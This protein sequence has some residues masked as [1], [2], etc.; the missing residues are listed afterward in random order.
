MADYDASGFAGGI[1]WYR[2]MDLRWHQ[3]TPFR[4]RT[5][6]VPFYFIGSVH[7]V[8]LEACHCEEPLPGSPINTKMRGGSR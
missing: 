5:C 3:R 2:A 7:Y 8:D 6:A 1:N 4:G